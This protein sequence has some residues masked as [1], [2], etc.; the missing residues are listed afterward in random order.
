LFLLGQER[1]DCSDGLPVSFHRL[2]SSDDEYY[3][4]AYCDP[5]RLSDDKWWSMRHDIV[6]DT[7][8]HVWGLRQGPLADV[9]VR[10][11]S[12]DGQWVILQ[13]YD[14]DKKLETSAW[15][16]A[17]TNGDKG[18]QTLR[19]ISGHRSS[20]RVAWSRDSQ[21]FAILSHQDDQGF[22][23][24]GRVDDQS[25]SLLAEL[26]Q[27]D[28]AG[29]SW[30]ADGHHISC[31]QYVID[32]PSGQMRLVGEGSRSP[33]EWSSEGDYLLLKEQKLQVWDADRNRLVPLGD[34]IRECKWAPDD[35]WLAC[36]SKTTVTVFNLLEQ[37]TIRADV[38]VAEVP[39]WSPSGRW[40]GFCTRE[41]AGETWTY[42]LH[43]VDTITRQVTQ[44]KGEANVCDIAWYPALVEDE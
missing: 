35:P 3:K 9:T 20:V 26:G 1:R 40:V 13:A 15:Y 8:D 34:D 39:E 7:W 31:G 17:R 10:Y 18:F 21:R 30:S 2:S 12:P 29:L 25:T 43:T 5:F 19:D 4:E 42:G 36:W 32:W 28:C 41:L 24:I 27:S 14:Q 37:D 33:V 44:I 6:L 23:W 16:I 11:F 38:A 22:I